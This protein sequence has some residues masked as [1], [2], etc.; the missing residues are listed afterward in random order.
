MAL[1]NMS[2]I[3]GFNSFTTK[4]LLE[5]FIGV[6]DKAIDLNSKSQ[7]DLEANIA[8]LETPEAAESMGVNKADIKV[9][10]Y[11]D[12]LGE[13]QGINEKLVA[14]KAEQVKVFVKEV[15]VPY[16]KWN[17]RLSIEENVKLKRQRQKLKITK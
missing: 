6:L 12:K 14:L 5:G 17:A 9:D 13:M 10:D 8:F 4:Y 16:Y 1:V 15:G 11:K 3:A 7:G 2:Q